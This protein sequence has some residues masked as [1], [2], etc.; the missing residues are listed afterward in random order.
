MKTPNKHI[1]DN[2]KMYTDAIVK[3]G[4]YD[5]HKVTALAAEVEAGKVSIDN[6][7]RFFL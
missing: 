4:A 2:G 5:H 1:R 3:V 6:F 7:F